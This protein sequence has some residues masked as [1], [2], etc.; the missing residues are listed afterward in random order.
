MLVR[1][2]RFE[3]AKSLLRKTIP[4]TRRVFGES[5]RLTL[6]MRKNHAKALYHDKSATLDD[7]REAVGTLEET[8]PIAR[9]VFGGAHPTVAEMDESLQTARQLLILRSMAAMSPP[10]G[11][12]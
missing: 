5:D 4:A 6:M 8:A 7:L 11:S 12:A 2:Q 9:R 10:T 3:E 1:V